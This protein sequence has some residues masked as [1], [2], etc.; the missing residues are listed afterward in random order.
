MTMNRRALAAC[1]LWLLGLAAMAALRAGE[2]PAGGVV[3]LPKFVVTDKRELPPPEAWRYGT[4]AGFEVLTNV[5][6]AATRRLL[7]DFEMFRQALSHVW[8]LPNRNQQPTTLILCGRGTKFDPF[9]PGLRAGAGS[10]TTLASVLLRGRDQTAIVIDM[11]STTLYFLNTTDGDTGPTEFAVEHDK[12]L[13]REYIRYLLTR[14]EPRSPAWLEEGLTQMIVRMRFGPNWIEF[15]K[16]EDP[17]TVG[18]GAAANAAL[19]EAGDDSEGSVALANEPA[20]DR[21]FNVALRHRALMPLQEMFDVAHDSPVAL[22]PL[23]NNRWAKQAYAFVHL[24]LYGFNG[25]F[26]KPFAQFVQRSA[27]EPVTE[28]LF[29]QCFKMN[30]KRMLDEIRGYINFTAYQAREFRAKENVIVAPKPIELREATPGEIGRIKGDALLVAGNQPAARTELIAAYVRGDRDPALLASLGLLEQAA[31]E[32]ER[33]RKFLE[34]ACAGRVDRPAAYVE[35]ARLRLAGTPAGDGRLSP[36]QTK[37]V[38]D[39]LQTA[40]GQLPP[41]AAVYEIAAETWTRSA[42]VPQREDLTFLIDGVRQFPGRMKLAYQA[43]VVCA[44]AGA[45]EP[46]HTLA[47]HGLKYAPDAATKA[48]FEELKRSLPPAPARN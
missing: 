34:A 19:A 45:A 12:Q 21:D 48:R 30:Y 11:A 25:R 16:V 9:V 10:E 13:Y 8:P 43:A 29:E 32:T 17:N 24:G 18:F 27:R 15:A 35:L 26:Q 7:R 22:S 1:G 6:D 44:A 41:M 5:S 33:A 38:L 4:L 40:R 14:T 46:A 20:E 23:G 2:A 31:G 3:E 47:D 42:A 39:L 36:A 37:S 28:A